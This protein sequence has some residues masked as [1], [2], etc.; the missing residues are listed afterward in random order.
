MLRGHELSSIHDALTGLL[1]RA[2]MLRFV[3]YLIAQNTRFTLAIIDLDNF[4]SINDNYGHRTG[5]EALIAVAD[6]LHSYIG[7]RGL[8]GRFGGDE[9]LVLNFDCRT[10]DE[11]HA[12]YDGMYFDEVVFRRKIHLSTVTLFMTATIGSAVFPQ[13]AADYDGLFALMDKALYRGKSKGRN[14]FIIYL[15]EKHAHL[16]I[17]KLSRH[18][19]YEAYWQMDEGICAGGDLLSRLRGAFPPLR[20]TL[21][22]R[23]IFLIDR[24]NRLLEVETGT[25]LAKLEPLGEHFEKE[26]VPLRDFSGLGTEQPALFRALD[27]LSFWSAMVAPIRRQGTLL[28]YLIFCPE[29]RTLRIWQDEDCA[30]IYILSR[31]IA[32]TTFQDPLFQPNE[33]RP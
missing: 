24:E 9:F 26:V 22:L 32:E 19:L 2:V 15:P 12:F 7:Q 25:V 21:R 4:K 29:E 17:P 10:Y 11:I 3:D 31:I 30:T 14:C 33:T 13:D 23:R 5:D 1:D 18:S 6:S 27:G 8:V 16:E 28:G 20:D